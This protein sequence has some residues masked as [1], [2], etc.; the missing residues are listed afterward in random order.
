MQLHF[1]QGQQKRG[2]AEAPFTVPNGISLMERSD[3]NILY[4]NG[5]TLS[6]LHAYG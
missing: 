3:S 1:Q 6:F 2:G 5:P 4:K